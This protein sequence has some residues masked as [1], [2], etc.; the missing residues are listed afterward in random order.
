MI[1]DKQL[2]FSDSQAV[3]GSSASTNIIDLGSARDIG[4]GEDLYLVI[5]A[6]TAVTAA[7]AA[8]VTFS[9][10]TDALS[11]FSSPSARFVSEAVGKAALTAGAK[12]VTV[13]IPH[14]VERYLRVYYTV[15]SGPLTGGAFSA[16]LT[17]DVQAWTAVAS[18]FATGT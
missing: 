2:E 5:Q 12:P 18:G 15:A 1:I 10:E 3:T 8:T 17:K 11:D 4:V 16:F 13:Q 7:G 14:G 9:L 6:D